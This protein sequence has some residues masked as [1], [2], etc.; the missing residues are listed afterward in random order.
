MQ[1]SIL[2]KDIQHQSHK[3]IEMVGDNVIY[4][5]GTI[6]MMGEEIYRTTGFGNG[7]RIL[8]VNDVK[9]KVNK[10]YSKINSLMYAI[11][12]VPNGDIIFNGAIYE[13]YNDDLM[14][15]IGGEYLEVNISEFIIDKKV[16]G[17]NN[18][19]ND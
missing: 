16:F 13:I 12:F 5:I 17:R 14:Q 10:I 18:N 11:N 9:E 3:K 6:S 4:Y 8:S 19:D 15:K 2:R 7:G 1:R